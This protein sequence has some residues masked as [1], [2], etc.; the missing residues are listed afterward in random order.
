MME[1]RNLQADEEPGLRLATQEFLSASADLKSSRFGASTCG[2]ARPDPFALFGGHFP[3]A[4]T[5]DFGPTRSCLRDSTGR[6]VVYAPSRD[7]AMVR[8]SD[9]VRPS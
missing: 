1:R 7:S 8:T 2:L 5:E 9:F 4:L 3:L 6:L